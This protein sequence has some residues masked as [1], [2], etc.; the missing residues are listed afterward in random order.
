[1]KNYLKKSAIV[2]IV[3]LSQI[4]T[5]HAQK[6]SSFRAGEELLFKVSFGFFDAAEAKMIIQPQ[7]VPFNEKSTY[8]IDVYGQ[9][10]GIFKL[11]SVNDNWGSY[12]DTSYI[13]PYQS[14][15]FIEEGRYRKNERVTFDHQKNKAHVKLF[16][17]ENKEV[18][19]TKEYKIPSNV[20]DIVSGFY[21][22]RTMDMK[23]YKKGDIITMTG[24]FDKEVYTIKMVYEK[25]EKIET[26]IGTFDAY[27]LSPIIPKN[28][29]FRGEQPV[30]VWV[31]DDLNKIPLRIKAKLI[32]GSLDMEIMDAKGLR[33]N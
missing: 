11:F 13:I 28:K 33:N 22:L 32:V 6:N 9:T 5:C 8:Q 17:R 20:Q 1:M 21:F 26:K 15:R 16:D 3:S 23:K 24:F 29:L 31:S 19:E 18:V 25:K 7:V 30:R 4:L 27:V 2:V 14:Y 10:L 12:V